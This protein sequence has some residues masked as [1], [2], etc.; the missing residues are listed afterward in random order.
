MAKLRHLFSLVAGTL[1]DRDAH[2]LELAVKKGVA[3]GELIGLDVLAEEEISV[4][5]SCDVALPLGQSRHPRPNETKLCLVF[6]TVRVQI[7]LERELD[8]LRLV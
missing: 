5:V 2:S 7:L 6:A 1:R 4:F 3:V 8:E